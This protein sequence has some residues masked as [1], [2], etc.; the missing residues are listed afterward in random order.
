MS[1][2]EIWQG[3][4][5]ISNVALDILKNGTNRDLEV[6]FGVAWAI[7]YNR[8]QAAFE[9]KCQMPDQIW[10]FARNLLGDYKGAL[11]AL[12][13]NLGDKNNAWTPPP[14]GVVKM[15]VDGA[16]SED[17][18]NSSVGVVIRDSYGAVIAACGKFLQGQFSVTEVEALAMEYGILL[19]RD[20]N[21]TQIIVE[22]DAI[23]IV[24]SIN[25]N[26]IEGSIGH[27]FQGIL[28]L[29]SSFS[30]WK[31]NHVKRDYNRA[32]HEAAHLARRSEG[33][34]VWIGVLLMA[35]QEIIQS[36]CIK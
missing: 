1:S 15:N 18:R 12:I 16:T 23:P 25:K 6:F 5:D 34:Q 4:G 27:L 35:V 32:T 17:G 13:M 30:S 24:N 31:V 2:V 9:S 33:S 10:R 8:N 7:W 20:M 11:V 21:L 22:S 3:F 26:F 36:E 14:P 29:L 28:A 19:A